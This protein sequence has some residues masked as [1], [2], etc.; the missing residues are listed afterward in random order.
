MDKIKLLKEKILSTE[1]EEKVMS[2]NDL[3][4]A[5]YNTKPTQTE[6]Y[7]KQALALAEEIGFKN[8]IARSNKTIGV[9]HH[10]KGDFDKALKYYYRAMEIFE[11]MEDLDNVAG[12]KLNI[13]GVYEKQGN[14]DKALKRYYEALVIWEKSENK[15]LMSASYNNIGIIYEKQ[16]NLELALEYHKKSLSLKEETGDRFGASV[17]YINL[18]N[19]YGNKEKMDL[20]MESYFNAEKIKKEIGDSKGLAACYINIGMICDM[21]NDK[22]AKEY[23]LKALKLFEEIEDKFG[24]ASTLSCLGKY[25]TGIQNFEKAQEFLEKALKIARDIKA[26]ELE[27]KAILS[28]SELYDAQANYEMSLKYYKLYSEL[29]EGIFNEQ[30]SI[31][32]A[33]MQTKYETEKKEKEAEIFKL[34]NVEL[35]TANNKLKIEICERKKAEAEIKKGRERL[36]IVNKILRHDLTN[37]L[38]VIKSAIRLYKMSSDE[39]MLGE[40]EIRVEKGLSTITRLHE[41]EVFMDSHLYLKEMSIADII[42]EIIVGYQNIEFKITGSAQVFADDALYSVFENLISNAIKHGN[43]TEI[44]ISMSEKGKFNQIKFSDNGIGVPD[45]IKDK[46]FDEGFIYGEYGHTGIGL[47]I[48]KQTVENYGGMMFVEDN[49]PN[50]A[51]FT[52]ILMKTIETK[53]SILTTEPDK[54]G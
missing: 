38:A 23:L 48:A 13:G 22:R 52:I 36:Q 21:E 27:G 50:G 8:G 35:A 6:E 37:D 14:F 11:K 3:A 9:S 42:N 29:N 26:K 17:S 44:D 2:L 5:L 33:E 4:F 45:E 28:L 1:G 25:S 41:Q 40:L 20:A 47:Y 16:K 51:V 30:K 46:I 15:K 24:V 32:I 34:K 31:Q 18:G 43:S 7:A 19:I 54:V 12:S 53:R 10:I 49:K 39:K